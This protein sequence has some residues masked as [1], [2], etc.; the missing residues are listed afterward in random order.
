MLIIW[1]RLS[2][3]GEGSAPLLFRVKRLYAP[4]MGK[5]SPVSAAE[6]IPRAS[7]RQKEFDAAS[8]VRR[9]G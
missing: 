7:Q 5:I 6:Q 4:G 9:S 2:A 8:L 1:P 3:R